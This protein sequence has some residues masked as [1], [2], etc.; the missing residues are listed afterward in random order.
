TARVPRTRPSVSAPAR[1]NF[2]GESHTP[3]SEVH[4]TNV[5]ETCAA[6]AEIKKK[7]AGVGVTADVY[8]PIRFLDSLV[9]IEDEVVPI[10]RG[11]SAEDPKNRLM[12]L[13]RRIEGFEWL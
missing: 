5:E 1:T 2:V 9:P 6:V 3:Q 11:T 12:F 13:V 10:V 4:P 7:W 8:F